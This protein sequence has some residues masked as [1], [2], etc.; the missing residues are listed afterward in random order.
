MFIHTIRMISMQYVEI[1]ACVCKDG[2]VLRE[3]DEDSEA[4]DCEGGDHRGGGIGDTS[5]DSGRSVD[6]RGYLSESEEQV[7]IYIKLFCSL[8]VEYVTLNTYIFTF[9][10]LL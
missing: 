1:C 8:L 5:S 2:E 4:R 6:Q 10:C 3:D 9:V 7:L